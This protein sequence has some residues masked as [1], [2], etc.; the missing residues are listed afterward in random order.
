MSFYKNV[1]LDAAG[2]ENIA[3]GHVENSFLLNPLAARHAVNLMPLLYIDKAAHYIARVRDDG[4]LVAA[5]TLYDGMVGP[6]TTTVGQISARIGHKRHGHGLALCHAVF[7]QAAMDH[8][9]LYLTPF[10]VEGAAASA[11]V[12]AIHEA[13]PAVRV[14]YSGQPAPITAQ[15]RYRLDV[16]PFGVVPRV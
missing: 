16:T 15:R 8:K 5:A 10:E 6:G 13:F 4:L 2:L 11:A 14:A 3:R 1:F 12:V 9:T 7:N